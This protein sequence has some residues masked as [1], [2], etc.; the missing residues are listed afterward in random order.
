MKNDLTGKT[1]NNWTVLSKAESNKYGALWNVRCVCGT[2]RKLIRNHLQRF[3][4]C[5]CLRYELQCKGNFQGCGELPKSYWSDLTNKARLRDIPFLISIDE[6]WE[7]FEKQNGKCALTGERLKFRR[8]NGKI[9]GT[10]SLDRI[11]S[12]KGYTIGN[13]QWIHKTVNAMKSNHPEKEF[14]D[15]CKKVAQYNETQII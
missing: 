10:A 1:I 3:K 14:I 8:K 13:I 11:D 2:E 6:A 12:T 15:F 5:G 4:S 9:I 7:L